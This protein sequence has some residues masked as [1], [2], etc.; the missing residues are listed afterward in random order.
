M[1]IWNYHQY[2]EFFQRN[3]SVVLVAIGISILLIVTFFPTIFYIWDPPLAVNDQNMASQFRIDPILFRIICILW[4]FSRT[5]DYAI[6]GS[7]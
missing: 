7:L 4:G 2:L 6:I 5:S 1:K 3:R